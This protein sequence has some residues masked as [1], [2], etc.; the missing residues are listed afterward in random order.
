[1]SSPEEEKRKEQIP[2]LQQRYV[3]GNNSVVK[4]Q[5]PSAVPEDAEPQEPAEQCSEETL[6][7]SRTALKHVS[8]RVLKNNTLKV[9]FGFIVLTCLLLLFYCTTASGQHRCNASVSF[10]VLL[11]ALSIKAGQR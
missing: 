4:P 10:T 11:Y 1:M 2:D 8:E 3:F 9:S 6:C 7:L 5:T